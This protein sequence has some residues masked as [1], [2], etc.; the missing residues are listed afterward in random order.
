LDI[1]IARKLRHPIY[2]LEI[3]ALRFWSICEFRDTVLIGAVGTVRLPET[4]DLSSVQR[5]LLDN[6]FR[7]LSIERKLFERARRRRAGSGRSAVLQIERERR[8][9]GRELHTGAGQMLA[10]IRWQLE[11]ISTELPEPPPKVNTALQS[12]ATLSAQTL[13]QVRSLSHRLHPPEWQRLTLE[14]AI[15]QLWEI[16]GIPQRLDATLEIDHLPGEPDFEIKVLFY[17]AFQEAL[18][19]ILRHS[20]ATRIE[21]ALKVDGPWLTLTIRDNGIGFDLGKMQTTP[22]NLASG[23]GLRSIR[24]MAESLG[25]KFEV[26]S[27]P[28]GTKLVISVT[29]YPA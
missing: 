20:Q 2:G 17:R 3:S 5:N 24:E 28:L 16:T 1:L 22:A 4:E 9:L 13:E 15:R 8:R 29:T 25:G 12:I 10:A 19:N 11:V 26:D 23:I 14:S 18:S 7:L 21:A 27:G 6:F